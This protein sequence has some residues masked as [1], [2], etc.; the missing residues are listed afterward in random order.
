MHA[1]NFLTPPQIWARYSHLPVKTTWTQKRGIK[2]I[3]AVCRRHDDDALICF[4]TI[5]F[6]QQLVEGLLA[7]VIATAVA[8]T[9][10]PTHRINFIDKQNTRRILFRLLK[11]IAH[12]ARTDAH[13]HF[14]KIRSRDR[15]KWYARLTGNRPCKQGLT[16]AR[17]A[18]QQ[19]A[20]RNFAA[21]TAKF[22][23][24]L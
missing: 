18:F 11:H 22:L 21:Q 5:H 16:R 3:F 10:R 24:V 7:L 1:Q 14:N 2:Y 9:A 4:K 6:N 19:C 13:K 12:A 15:E 17:R 20:L 8:C 23:R